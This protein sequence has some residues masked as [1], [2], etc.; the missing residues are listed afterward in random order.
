M[1]SKIRFDLIPKSKINYFLLGNEMT[2]MLEFMFKANNNIF[3]KTSIRMSD[4]NIMKNISPIINDKS[5][6]KVTIFLGRI[7]FWAQLGHPKIN[8]WSIYHAYL[9]PRPK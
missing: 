4:L 3:M 6:C 9:S 8:I 5:G 7:V 1:F 2:N